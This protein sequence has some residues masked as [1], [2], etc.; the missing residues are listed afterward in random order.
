MIRVH[1]CVRYDDNGD[2]W[3]ETQQSLHWK[4]RTFRSVDLLARMS[5]RPLNCNMQALENNTITEHMFEKQTWRGL[6]S[7]VEWARQVWDSK[8]YKNAHNNSIFNFIQPHHVL[9][10]VCVTCALRYPYLFCCA[11]H[12]AWFV[13]YLFCNWRRPLLGAK[14]FAKWSCLPRAL[15]SRTNKYL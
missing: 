10:L 1:R 3:A 4:D 11:S 5:L 13:L 2:Y 8:L 9:S 15:R 12:L 7:G 14:H 6:S